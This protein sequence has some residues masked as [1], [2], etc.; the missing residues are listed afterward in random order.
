M[1]KHTFICDLLIFCV[2]I[3]VL[4]LPPLLSSFI[5]TEL[6]TIEYNRFPFQQFFF[7]ITIFTVYFFYHNKD[8]SLNS[9]KMIFYRIIFPS[10]FT[11]CI[12]FCL[13]LFVT[14]LSKILPQQIQNFAIRDLKLEKPDNFIT[15]INC[16]LTFI[17]GAFYEELLYRFYLSDAINTLFNKKDN[18]SIKIIVEI[19]VTVIFSLSHLYLGFFALVNSALAHIILRK[20]YLKYKNIYAGIIAHFF[21]NLLTLILL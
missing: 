2:I 18:K 19:L 20:T 3:L 13:S 14:F 16:L 12:L 21:Y 6:N 17:L 7:F 10:T 5:F 1:N 9:S 15:C 11:F 4:V 8:S